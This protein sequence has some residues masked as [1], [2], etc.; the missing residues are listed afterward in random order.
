MWKQQFTRRSNYAQVPAPA[1]QFAFHFIAIK[2]ITPSY[3]RRRV[4]HPDTGY[5]RACCKII[6][7]VAY[8]SPR[9]F[10]IIS[11]SP[12]FHGENG[13]IRSVAHLDFIE[14]IVRAIRPVL[15]SGGREAFAA[16]RR[17]QA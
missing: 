5:G 4:L 12:E 8:A 1:R 3:P 7:A 11:V 2:L 6:P 16:T 14:L 15:K 13:E 10:A 9:K 17:Q